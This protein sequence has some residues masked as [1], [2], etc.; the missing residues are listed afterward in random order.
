MADDGGDEYATLEGLTALHDKSLLVVDRDTQSLPRYRMLET[1]RQYAQERLDEAGEADEVRNRH[2]LYYVEVAER[3]G[4]ELQ[5]ARQGEWFA[6]L[7]PEQENLL[8]AHAWCAHAP[9]GGVLAL[10]LFASLWRFW[11]VTAQPETGYRLAEEALELAGAEPDSPDRGNTL[12]A[13]SLLALHLGRY[14]DGIP[15]AERALAMGRALR[16]GALTARA[17]NA[18]GALLHASGEN[19]RALA[20]YVEALAVAETADEALQLGSALNG[21]GEIKRDAGELAEAEAFYE[22]AFCVKTGGDCTTLCNLAAVLTGQG[23]LDRAC[24]ALTE[25]LA[26][27]RQIG[28][29]GHLECAMDVAAALATASGCHADAARF[30]GA[31]FALMREAGTRHEPVDERFV[32]A[33]MTAARAAM[34]PAAFDAEV[35]GGAR[36]GHDAAVAAMDRWLRER[37]PA[38]VPSA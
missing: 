20:A 7:R 17:L 11:R 18:L 37:V 19:A 5:G 12:W 3:A 28:N 1:V 16:D 31:A 36:Q 32:A 21:I 6:A 24:V 2:V 25:S 15:S 13:M 14:A 35:A 10:R 22:R 9:R 8:A 23:K 4:P 30:H 33:S 27:A 29:K 38:P 34:G 26:I